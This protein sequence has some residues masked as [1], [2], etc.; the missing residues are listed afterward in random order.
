MAIIMDMGRMGIDFLSTNVK[1]YDAFFVLIKNAVSILLLVGYHDAARAFNLAIEPFSYNITVTPSVSAQEIYSD[2][3]NLAPSGKE[4]G[5][6][7]TDISPGIS[8]IGQSARSQLNLNYRMQNLYNAGGNNELTTSNQLQ[9]NS[10]NT[11]IQN[12]LFLDSQSSIS[13]QNLNSERIA[14]DNISGAVGSTT[15]ST[16]GLSPY[17]TPQF[18]NYASGSLRVNFNT[19][20]TDAA[21]SNKTGSATTSG[22][23]DS[24]TLA[25]LI[26]LNSGSEFQRFNW[27]LSHNNTNNYR[28]NAGKVGS[29]GDVKFQNSM[30]TIRTSIHQYFNLFVNGGYSN[31]SFQTKNN[32][33]TNGLSYTFG[34]Q[35]TPSQFYSVEV[36]IGNNNHITVNVA[37]IQRLTW[38]TTFRK[39]DIGLNSGKT[40]QTALNY[41]TSHST[42]SLTHDNDTTTAQEILLQQRTFNVQDSAGNTIFDPVTNQAIQRSISLPTLTNDVIVRQK[43]NFSASYNTGK[44]TIGANAFNEDRTFE[45]TGNTQTVKGIS[46]TWDWQFATKT[47][48]YVRPLWQQTEG[49]VT[50]SKSDRYD[51]TVGINESIT[52]NI[53]GKLEF[54]HLN[55]LS[56]LNLANDYQENRATASLFMRY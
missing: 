55:Q 48:A 10:H 41:H 12:R 56:D 17:W 15:V 13:Q 50:N 31:N 38:A 45:L 16:F 33:N 54:R 51:F 37:P 20:T 44:S 34:G 39:N 32:Q 53:N 2:N 43:W 27:S 8:I 29:S 19:V 35:W 6:F 21:S 5:A 9:Y 25:E 14:N 40:W 1:K 52:Q 26:Q 22:I 42:W 3:I 30:A 23:S 24:M 47:S 18:G 11:F 46:A 28:D 7:V 4:K 36:G 49:G